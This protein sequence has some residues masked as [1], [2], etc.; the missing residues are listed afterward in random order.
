MKKSQMPRILKGVEVHL[1]VE[2]KRVGSQ[3]VPALVGFS[4]PKDLFAPPLS[5]EHPPAS[6]EVE[7]NQ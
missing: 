7:V 6:E 3:T 4:F 2:R 1:T 5:P